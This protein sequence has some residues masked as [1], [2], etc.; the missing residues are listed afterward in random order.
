MYLK[1]IIS[2]IFLGQLGDAELAGGALSIGFANITGYSVIKGLAI[3]MEPICY[4]AYGAQKWDI[5]SQTFRRTLFLLLL[6]VLPI[7]LLWVN[8]DWILVSFGQDKDITIV[9]K[10]YLTYSIPDLVAQAHLH[11]LKTLLRTQNINRPLTISATC[12]TVLHFPISYLL[13]KYFNL[14]VR[15]V[16]LASGWHSANIF[17]GLTVY[18][19]LSKR[20]IKPWVGALT[21]TC[22]QS[23]GS[24]L[25]LAGSSVLSVCLE[26]WWYEIMIL[27]S[28]LLSNPQTNVAAM[29]IL[30]QLTSLL[31]VFPSSLSSSLST[32]IGHELGANQP[33]YAR[34]LAI[35]GLTVAI[36]WGF[37]AFAFTIL[38]RDAW[39]KLYTQDYEILRLTSISIPIIGFCEL[40]NSPQTAACGILIGSARPTVG[41]LINFISFYAIGLP[42]AI[43]LAFKMEYGFVG[44][45]I[46]LAAAQISCL[47]MMVSVLLS[48]NWT[49][50]ATRAKGLTQDTQGCN[51]HS[52][53]SLLN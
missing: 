23:W 42:T 17:L 15:G 19:F 45:W 39:G 11:P 52:E 29:G 20:P 13:V 2:T 31:Y 30:I 16:A 5:I 49:Y 33:A 9:A 51:Y 8:M 36:L 14:G 26:W 22:S 24:L 43:L 12:A 4:Q 44:L 18:L 34:D 27:L 3:G 37:S 28:G 1:S 35:I 38:I 25:S 53:A 10:I 47:C 32:M 7:S 40:G 21:K 46:G 41:S 48:T 6:A 50:E